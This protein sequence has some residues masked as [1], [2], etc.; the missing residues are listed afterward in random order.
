MTQILNFIINVDKKMIDSAT[1]SMDTKTE[2]RNSVTARVLK[3][4]GLYETPGQRCIV[5]VSN[6][7]HW[8]FLQMV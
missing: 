4:N 1:Q 7:Q 3:K 2:I 5:F 6:S 8:L